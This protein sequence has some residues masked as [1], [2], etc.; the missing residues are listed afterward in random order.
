[1]DE[2]ESK[3]PS[4]TH[5]IQGIYNYCDRWC[6]RCHFTDRCL[7]YQQTKAYF[8]ESTNSQ[9]ITDDE[10]M[11]KIT[12]IFQNSIQMLKQ[13]AKERGIDLDSLETND[14][15]DDTPPSL[16]SRIS[17]KYVI[18]A[19]EWFE[20]NRTALEEYTKQWV[21]NTVLDAG[22]ADNKEKQLCAEALE[23]IGWHQHQIHAKLMR[24]LE[25]STFELKSD[26]QDYPSDSDGSAKVVLIS[27]DRSIGA[28]RNVL[29]D[30]PNLPKTREVVDLLE[31]LRNLIE[32]AF[33]NASSII[34]PGFD[35]ADAH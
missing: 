20:I 21:G 30:Q 27:I 15:E 23:V 9:E 26:S 35:D 13:I 12:G 1:M 18:S 28:Y 19:N 6:E 8:P 29:A 24:A 5:Y 17:M 32:T 14:K 7:N 10:F 33:P 2:I 11:A 31:R 34:R 22:V 16:L 3:Q 4:D 25:G